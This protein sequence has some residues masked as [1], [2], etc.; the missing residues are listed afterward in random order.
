MTYL[1]WIYLLGVVPSG[2]LVAGWLVAYTQGVFPSLAQ[3]AYTS[4]MAHAI[5][6]GVA[7]GFLWPILLPV[8]YSLTERAQ[9]GWSLQRGG[10]R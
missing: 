5:L 4:D 7:G 10:A 9:C 8:V 2:V 1:L 6:I 3:K